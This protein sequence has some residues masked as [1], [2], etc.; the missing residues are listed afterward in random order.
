MT[1]HTSSRDFLLIPEHTTTSHGVLTFLNYLFIAVCLRPELFAVGQHQ[2]SASSSRDRFPAQNGLITDNFLAAWC[3]A[4]K[5][6][7]QWL[8]IDLREKKDIMAFALQGLYDHSWIETFYIQ[9]SIDGETW[10]CYGSENGHK[11]TSLW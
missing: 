11:V 10:Y 8:Q 9:Y 3:A 2:L 6:E 7:K 1:S 5:D 4:T